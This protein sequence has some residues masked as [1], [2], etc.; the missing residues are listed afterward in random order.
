MEIY[1]NLSNLINLISQ[2]YKT[3]SVWKNEENEGS[4][5]NME[6][7]RFDAGPEF[8][9]LLRNVSR[10]IGFLYNISAGTYNR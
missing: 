7:S 2:A 10:R 3:C 4:F 9:N 5:E 6:R 8:Q 1:L